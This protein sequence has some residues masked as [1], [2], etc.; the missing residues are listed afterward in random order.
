MLNLPPAPG[1]VEN[2]RATPQ[3]ISIRIDWD[4]PST[5]NGVITHNE[6]QYSGP[7]VNGSINTTSYS[8]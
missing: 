1:P 5:P 8:L 4:P 2:L 3:L 7:N 6:I